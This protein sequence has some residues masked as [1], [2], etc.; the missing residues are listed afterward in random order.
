ME[1]W[2]EGTKAEQ[3]QENDPSWGTAVAITAAKAR[4]LVKSIAEGFGV[5]LGYQVEI[6]M[7]EPPLACA[8][9]MHAAGDTH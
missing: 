6:R 7:Y 5:R 1:T 8:K 4:L 2:V 3:Q 9:P